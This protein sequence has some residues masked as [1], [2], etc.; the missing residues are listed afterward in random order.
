MTETD[1]QINF[2]CPAEMKYHCEEVFRGEY[3][4]AF[5]PERPLTILDIGANCGAFSLWAADRWPGSFIHAYEPAQINF[6]YLKENTAGHTQIEIH[7]LAI[8][9]SD[10]LKLYVGINNQG[11]ASFYPELGQTEE[12]YEVPATM[13]PENLPDCDILKIDTE[14]C[15]FEIIQALAT[16]N[17]LPEIILLEYHSERDRRA[18]DFELSDHILIG[19][20]ANYEGR[21]IVKYRRKNE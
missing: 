19:S 1:K 18:L 15:E 20:H 6:H 21:G 14:G 4:I 12:T 16:V 2:T 11:E 17:R 7:K 5:S 9:A 8:L 10:R 13:R 3:D